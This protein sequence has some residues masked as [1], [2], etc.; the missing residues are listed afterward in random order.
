MRALSRRSSTLIWAQK[1]TGIDL[2]SVN[3]D[4]LLSDLAADVLR[5]RVDFV[6]F[7]VIYYFHAD[8]EDASLAQSLIQMTELAE[9]AS[10]DQCPEQIR[11]A[12]AILRRAIA[13]TAVVLTKKFVDTRKDQDPKAAF[14]AMRRDH[15]EEERAKSS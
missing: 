4:G 3:A 15:L 8:T 7:P 2:L 12:A 13:Q 9:R 11:L 1:Q 10:H 6:H 5:I 14:E